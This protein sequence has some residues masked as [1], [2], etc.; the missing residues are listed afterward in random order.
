MKITT[1]TRDFIGRFTHKIATG[2]IWSALAIAVASFIIQLVTFSMVM[3]YRNQ[4]ADD[5]DLQDKKMQVMEARFESMMLKYKVNTEQTMQEI[6]QLADGTTDVSD[7]AL[8]I[9]KNHQ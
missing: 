6:I 3:E 5:L 7:A 1:Y 2:L 8:H 4:M 9:L